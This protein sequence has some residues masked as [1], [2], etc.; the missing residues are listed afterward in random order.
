MKPNNQ[1]NGDPAQTVKPRMPRPGARLVTSTGRLDTIAVLVGGYAAVGGWE[2]S[3]HHHV[4]K[5]VSAVLARFRQRLIRQERS[6]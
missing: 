6:S 5:V 2:R 3:V 4:E 1:G